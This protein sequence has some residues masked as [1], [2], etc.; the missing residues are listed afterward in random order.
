VR[1]YRSFRAAAVE[2]GVS[3]IHAGAHFRF[4]HTQGERLGIA[5]AQHV[6]ERLLRLIGRSQ[7]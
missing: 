6:T 5:T 2:A 3:A 1:Q 4:D 7:S